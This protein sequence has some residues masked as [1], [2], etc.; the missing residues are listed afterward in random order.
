V[1]RCAAV[2]TAR[3]KLIVRPNGQSELYDVGADPTLA[4]NLWDERGVRELQQ[5]LQARLLN[6]YIDTSGVPPRERDPRGAAVLDRPPQLSHVE[7]LSR[8]LDH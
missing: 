8:L 7:P 1:S 3:H 2:R 5:G 4:N 6:W